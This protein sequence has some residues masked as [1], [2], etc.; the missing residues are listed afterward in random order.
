MIDK[1]VFAPVVPWQ[2]IA[3][4][5]GLSI[6]MLAFVVVRHGI[7]PLWRFL[8]SFVITLALVDP[9]LVREDLEIQKNIVLVL[10]ARTASQ[11]VGKRK[12]LT[13]K[14]LSHLRDQIKRFPQTELRVETVHDVVPQPQTGIYNEGT[15]MMSSLRRALDALPVGR[16]SGV[17]LISDGQVHDMSEEITETFTQTMKR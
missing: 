4:F 2:V 16:L 17:V 5:E 3:A 11:S 6:L 7:W 9:R 15:L 1:L 12:T 8:A 13:N 14:A 10:V